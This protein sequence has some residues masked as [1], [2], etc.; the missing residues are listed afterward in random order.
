[1]RTQ[2][3]TSVNL[4]GLGTWS[5]TSVVTE[6]VDEAL[7]HLNEMGKRTPV[8]PFCVTSGHVWRWTWE[9]V[10]ALGYRC[11]DTVRLLP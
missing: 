9:Y 3:I 7:D 11:T 8:E 4:P 5:I 2:T 1:M 6:S 10:N